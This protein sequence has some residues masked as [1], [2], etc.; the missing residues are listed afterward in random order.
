MG[1]FV[2]TILCIA[3]ARRSQWHCTEA[4]PWPRHDAMPKNAHRP[5][6]A[7]AHCIHR[8]RPSEPLGIWKRRV[9]SWEKWLVHTAF[10]SVGGEIR[11]KSLRKYF[12]V[13]AK[14]ATGN[15]SKRAE[16]SAGFKKESTENGTCLGFGSEDIRV[17][18]SWDS[19]SLVLACVPIIGPVASD[20]PPSTHPSV[21]P[22]KP[23]PV[24]A[25]PLHA[26]IPP[27]FTRHALARQLSAL[28]QSANRCRPCGDCYSPVVQNVPS[29]VQSLPSVDDRSTGARPSTVKRIIRRMG[30]SNTDG[31]VSSNTPSLIVVRRT[32]PRLC[33]TYHIF[34]VPP[35]R[36]APA[37]SRKASRRM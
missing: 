6:G 5:R 16:H 24:N 19:P 31:E 18:K 4:H 29:D 14:V 7:D 28:G 36:V 9:V 26:S 10:I 34:K 25:H 17:C 27:T 32:Y 3:V 12:V 21:P 1:A 22:A 33:R 35:V 8:A 20:S 37:V 11:R 23:S 2:Y 30:L 15:D 13:G